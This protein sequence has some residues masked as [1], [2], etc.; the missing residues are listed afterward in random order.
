MPTL[1]T[2]TD[3]EGNIATQTTTIRDKITSALRYTTYATTKLITVTYSDGSVIT[4]TTTIPCTSNII[5]PAFTTIEVSNGSSATNV[6]SHCNISDDS[7]K[8]YI[9]RTTYL[10]STDTVNSRT[11]LVPSSISGESN[12]I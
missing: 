6:V 12:S 9:A 10:A 8:P 3:P 7:G 4:L 11:I 2:I 1:V 5:L